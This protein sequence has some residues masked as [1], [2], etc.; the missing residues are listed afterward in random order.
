MRLPRHDHHRRLLAL[1][2]AGLLPWVVVVSN[3]AV[4]LVLAWGLAD[5]A[6]ADVTTLPAY[7]RFTGGLAVSRALLAWPVA[8]VLYLVALASGLSGVV[9]DREDRRVT[10]GLLV[11]VGATLLPVAAGVGRDAGVAAVPVGSL[12]CWAAAWFGWREGLYGLV[13]LERVGGDSSVGESSDGEE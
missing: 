9:L 8:T 2:A 4:G 10:A 5:P 6:T 3:G 12:V 1:L 7:V 11:L 13:R